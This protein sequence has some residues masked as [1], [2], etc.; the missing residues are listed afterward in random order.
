[1]GIDPKSKYRIRAGLMHC[2]K[3]NSEKTGNTFIYKKELF[4]QAEKILGF[5]EDECLDTFS[6]VIDELK[7]ESQV[8]DFFVNRHEIVN[9]F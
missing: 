2:L 3:D 9:A 4:L 7:I 1:M 5:E 6:S 8:L